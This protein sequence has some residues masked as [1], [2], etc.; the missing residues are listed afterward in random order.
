MKTSTLAVVVV[1]VLAVIGLGWWYYAKAPTT[2]PA[3]TTQTSGTDQGMQDNGVTAGVS[4]T[5]TVSTAPMSAT[6][7]YGANG[8]SPSEVTIK[9]GGT[10]TWTNN[11][12]GTMWV[13]SAQHPTHTAYSGTTLAQHCG[14][15][16]EASSFDQCKNGTT[17][18]FTF[19]KVGTW[20]YH[21]HSNAS[22]FGKVIVVE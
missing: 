15:A 7:S 1:V 18:S 10:V 13:A 14:S 9:K 20:G 8:F 19:N 21:N 11:S 12:G 22:Q 5:V 6:I 16:E 3:D 17:Y 2:A 4:G